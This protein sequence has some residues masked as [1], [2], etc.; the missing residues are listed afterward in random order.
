MFSKPDILTVTEFRK[1]KKTLKKPI[2]IYFNEKQW[3]NLTHQLKPLDEKPPKQT[4]TLTL[5]QLPDIP[6]GFGTLRCPPECS[7]ITL[8]EGRGRC[9]CPPDLPSPGG[10]GNV[11]I[12]R[13]FCFLVVRSDGTVTCSGACYDSKRSCSLGMWKTPG[14]IVLTMTCS[15]R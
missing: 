4:L 15:C 10:S 11:T 14:S 3:T 2:V 5:S 12:P 13:Q 7:K 9:I 6:G 8:E 1:L